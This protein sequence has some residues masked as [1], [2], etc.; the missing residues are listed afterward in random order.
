M[1]EPLFSGWNGTL[2]GSYAHKLEGSGLLQVAVSVAL[3]SLTLGTM[4]GFSQ[5]ASSSSLQQPR[6]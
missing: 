4:D 3:T 6:S 1:Q 2:L 5:M